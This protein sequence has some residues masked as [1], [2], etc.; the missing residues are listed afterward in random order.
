MPVIEIPDFGKLSAVTICDELKIQ[1]QNDREKLAEAK[2]KLY[3][4]GFYDGVSNIFVIIF[5]W[6]TYSVIFD[7]LLSDLEKNIEKFNIISAVSWFER[8]YY[9]IWTKLVEVMEFQLSYFK[10]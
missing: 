6:F 2:E 10:S 3:L 4:R 1:S 9:K 7:F 5:V 8:D